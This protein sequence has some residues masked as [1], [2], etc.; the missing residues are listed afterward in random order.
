MIIIKFEGS[1]TN[2]VEMD[3]LLKLR[4]LSTLF[5]NAVNFVQNLVPFVVSSAMFI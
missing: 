1:T 4:L 3:G 2:L 5:K